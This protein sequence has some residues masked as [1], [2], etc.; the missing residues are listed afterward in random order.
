M[1][2]STV[3]TMHV[4]QAYVPQYQVYEVHSKVYMIT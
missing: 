3:Q 1:L 4:I 2:D